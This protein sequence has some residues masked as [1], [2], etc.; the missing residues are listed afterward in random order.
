MAPHATD[1]SISLGLAERPKESQA[2]TRNGYQSLPVAS[3]CLSYWH[4]TTRAW[5]LLNHNEDDPVPATAK[6]CIIGSGL[7]GSVTAWS[8]VESGVAGHDILIIEAREAVSGASGRNAGHCRPDAFRGFAAY[9]RIHGAEQAKKI[10]ENE[11]LVFKKVDDFVEKHKVPCDWNSTTTFDVCLTEE[12]AAYEKGSFE[13]YQAAGGDV[14]QVQFFEG[15]EAK[16]RTKV[17]DA[18]A[19]YEWPAGSA[20]PAKLAQWILSELVGRGVQL[21]THCPAIGIAEHAKD[22]AARWDLQTP[23]GTVSAETIIHCTNAYSAHLLPELSTFVTPNRAQAHSFVPTKPLSGANALRSTMSLR[24][25]LKHFFSFIQRLGDGTVVFGTSRDN[26][27]WSQAARESIIG[28]DDTAY[29]Q[30]AAESAARAF[31]T[32][33]PDEGSKA[34]RHGEGADHYWSGIIAM[35]PDS[36]P[37]VGAIEG[38][39]GQYICAGHNGHGMARIWTCAPGAVKLMLGESW[40]ATGLPECF[41]YSQARLDK[42]AKQNIKSVW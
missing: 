6:Y 25:S 13:A 27:E 33:F 11:K 4:R 28:F 22:S 30:E 14:S 8:L 2:E 41:Q 1:T 5:P 26:P 10:I 39:E 20:H 32:L 3:P 40:E 15:E 23:R 42:A 12:F 17:K 31:R 19:A 18:V 21:W 7:S 9:A 24:Y 36:V 34:S 37:M 16:A 38:K 35:T 29:N